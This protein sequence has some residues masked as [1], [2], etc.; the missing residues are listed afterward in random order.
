M[1]IST[2][3]CDILAESTLVEL[4]DNNK[5]VLET[6]IKFSTITKFLE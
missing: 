6:K 4:I 2:S 3:K 1:I 5:L